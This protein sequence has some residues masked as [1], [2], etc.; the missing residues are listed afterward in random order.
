MNEEERY[1]LAR[2]D[3]DAIRRTVE[4]LGYSSKFATKIKRVLSEFAE[5]TTYGDILNA[6]MESRKRQE[7][8]HFLQGLEQKFNEKHPRISA[9]LAS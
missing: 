9:N 5:I 6:Y 7:Y 1:P 2:I 8:Y 3:F 4:R